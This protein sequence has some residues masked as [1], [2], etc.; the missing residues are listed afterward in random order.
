MP[1]KLGY[2][3]GL[4]AWLAVVTW[5]CLATFDTDADPGLNIPHLDKAVH[6]A[7]YFIA[8]LLAYKALCAWSAPRPPKPWAMGITLVLLAMYGLGIEGLQACCTANRQADVWDFIANSAGIFTAW[9]LLY[10]VLGTGRV[11][12]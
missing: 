5:A 1:K 8:G 10:S 4:I 3:L 11:L 12:K 9:F 7:F 2:T 6:F